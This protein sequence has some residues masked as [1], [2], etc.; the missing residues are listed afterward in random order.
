[1]SLTLP[2]W[3]GPANATPRL[4]TSRS[5]MNPAYG[6][7]DQRLNRAG[8]RYAWDIELPPQTYEN[9]QDW[10][11][12]DTE[13]QTCILLIPQPGLDT[14]APGL[15][16]VDGAG[17]TGTTLALRGLTANYLIRRNQWLSILTGG[18]WYSYRAASAVI[19]AADG[20]VDVPL[21]TMIR[22]AH[23]DAD[24]VDLAE[25]KVEGFPTP[26]PDAWAMGPDGLVR[27]VFSLKE[28]E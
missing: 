21:R 18:Q 15:S 2:T 23:A 4:I 22:K 11:D 10:S 25:P 8:S 26:A 20:T 3:P 1:M 16:V 27:L 9:A 13:D 12:I 24:R 5:E 7:P 19:V 17:Q 28:I 14:G 6:G